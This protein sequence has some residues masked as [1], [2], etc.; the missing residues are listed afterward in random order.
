MLFVLMR[1]WLMRRS[2]LKEVLLWQYR[3]QAA[4]SMTQ[5][6]FLIINFFI[7]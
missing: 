5:K 7:K 1:M 3:Q 2:C 6:Q 4:A